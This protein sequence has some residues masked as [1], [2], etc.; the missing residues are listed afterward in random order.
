MVKYDSAAP[1]ISLHVP[2]TAGTSLSSILAEWFPDGRLLTHYRDGARMPDKHVLTGGVCVHGH[3][4]GA[5]GLG[6]WQYYPDVGQFVTFLREPFARFMSQWSYLNWQKCQGLPIPELDDD[7]DFDTWINRRADEQAE[8]CNAFSF[9][10]QMPRPPSYG[11]A[12]RIIDEFMVFVGITER[13][14]DSVAALAE[15]L[16]KPVSHLPHLNAGSYRDGEFSS[17][18]SFH[19][20]RFSDEHE[21]YHVALTLNGM[22]TALPE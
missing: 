12:G 1:L 6:A 7:P 16:G 5:R 2:K 22:A 14:G 19:E 20:K 11:N 9:L 10:R 15:A 8:G 4:N 13:F 3:F 17:W 18:R 21:F